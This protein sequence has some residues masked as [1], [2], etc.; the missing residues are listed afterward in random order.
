[1]SYISTF[2][3]K[4]IVICLSSF[5]NTLQYFIILYYSILPKFSNYFCLV[6]KSQDFWLE[7]SAV[8]SQ[9]HGGGI[10]GQST[11]HLGT[12]GSLTPL[13]FQKLAMCNSRTLNSCDSMISHTPW[14]H[15]FTH[16]WM[17][18]FTYDFL[19][20]FWVYSNIRLKVLRGKPVGCLRV[21]S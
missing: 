21:A 20:L 5:Y 17:C 6:P 4:F 3:F 7:C 11:Y 8:P 10:R 2:F 19:L 1:M 14:Y 16:L 13:H 15:I 9:K 18:V 12:G